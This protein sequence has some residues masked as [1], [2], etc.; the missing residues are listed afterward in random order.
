MSTNK[1]FMNYPRVYVAC[2]GCYNEGRLNGKWVDAD[3]YEDY[4]HKCKHLPCPNLCFP[5]HEEYAIHDYDFMPN[6]GE[7]PDVEKVVEVAEAVIEHGFSIVND[8]IEWGGDGVTTISDAF[9]TRLDGWNY[10]KELGE[11]LIHEMCLMEIPDEMSY[12]FDYEAYGRDMSVNT[13]YVSDKG[14]VFWREC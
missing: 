10:N 12:Y 1:P 13:F 2:L 9:V 14:N 4:T 7:Y 8:F 3:E 5:N 6:L 11:Y